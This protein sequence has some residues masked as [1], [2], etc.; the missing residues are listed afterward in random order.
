ML[1]G[2]SS[3]SATS[4]GIEVKTPWPISERAQMMVTAL[5]VPTLTQ[6]LGIDPGALALAGSAE[7]PLF[8]GITAQPTMRPLPNSPPVAMTLV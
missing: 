5:S 7:G 2:T 1:I 6:A 4:I 8:P 3:S